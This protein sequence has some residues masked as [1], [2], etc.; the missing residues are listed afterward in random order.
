MFIVAPRKTITWPVMISLPQPGGQFKEFSFEVDFRC[1][2]EEEVRR[3]DATVAAAP[4][5]ERLAVRLDGWIE[6]W[7]KIKDADGND[8]AYSQ[9]VLQGLLD[10]IYGIPLSTALL[11]GIAEVRTGARQK[12]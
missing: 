2:E 3:L 11:N 10:S 1:L 8:I 7:R 9:P 5:T 12:N 4:E 6:G